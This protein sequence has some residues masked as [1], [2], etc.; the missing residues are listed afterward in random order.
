M[1]E[2]S[3]LEEQIMLSI[4]KLKDNAYGTTIY[5]NIVTLTGKDMA[6]GGIYF[7]LERLVKKGLLDAKKGIPTP[8]RGGQSKRYYKIT[9]L[10]FVGLKNTRELQNSFWENLPEFDNNF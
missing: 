7:P 6:I 3:K 4:W 8:E 10:G 5:E 2:L 9:K 1:S